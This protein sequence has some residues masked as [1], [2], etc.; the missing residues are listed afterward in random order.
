MACLITCLRPILKIFLYECNLC[1]LEPVIVLGLCLL[2]RRTIIAFIGMFVK[3]NKLQLVIW[4]C[5]YKNKDTP[6]CFMAKI[7][8]HIYN[9]R[10][11]NI[12]RINS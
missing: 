5:Y 4:I 3:I 11:I 7:P 1:M 9:K 2:Q 12:F 8:N 6:S 10:K